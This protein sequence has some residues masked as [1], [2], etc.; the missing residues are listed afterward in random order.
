MARSERGLRI[1][2]RLQGVGFLVVV[3]LLLGLTVAIYDTRCRGSPTGQGHAA[4][5]PVG[6]Q[7]VVPRLREA[8]RHHHRPGQ[9]REHDRATRRR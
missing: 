2:R 3:V 5:Q 1:R 8:R 6:N 7:L 9:R 4:G